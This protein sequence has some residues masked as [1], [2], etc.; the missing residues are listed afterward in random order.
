MR[1]VESLESIVSSRQS[2]VDS[3]QSAVSSRQSTVY[4]SERKCRFLI[5]VIQLGAFVF[6]IYHSIMTAI[7]AYPY[8]SKI[9]FDKNDNNKGR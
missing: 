2:A 6:N 4:Q 9:N 5:R 7:C 8:T 3:Q 1:E